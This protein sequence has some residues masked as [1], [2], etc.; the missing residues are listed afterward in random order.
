MDT[1][2]LPMGVSAE[3]VS[4]DV[5]NTHVT[6]EDD[7]WVHYA[8][9]LKYTVGTLG[10]I[11]FTDGILVDYSKD[12]ELYISHGDSLGGLIAW[13]G[14]GTTSFS[15]ETATE[16]LGTPSSSLVESSGTGNIFNSTYAGTFG[17]DT[18]DVADDTLNT[19][20]YA[21]DGDDT[22]TGNSA[23]NTI[24]GGAG[25]DTLDGGG[26]SDVLYGGA[27][28]DT[29][30]ASDGATLS[31]GTGDDTYVFSPGGGHS[32]IVDT[33]GNNTLKV[34]TDADPSTFTYTRV[35]DDLKIEIAS[36]VTISNYYTE[37]E[38]VQTIVT[39]DGTTTTSFDLS[40]FA[41]GAD[42][43]P[44]AADD[45]IHVL[46]DVEH[47]G[48]VL[49]SNHHGPDLDAD[50]DP[51]SVTALDMDTVHGHVVLNTDG[52]FAYTPDSSYTGTDSFDYTLLDGRGASDTA[53]VTLTVVANQAPIANDDSF[54]GVL[55]HEVIGNV[56]FNNGNGIDSD[57][58]NDAI[59]VTAQDADTTDGH[60]VLNTDGSFTYTPTEGFT[61]TDS[62][63]YTLTDSYGA[64]AT[65][66]ATLSI[67]LPDGYILGTSGIDVLTGGD[68]DNTIF[69]YEGDDTLDGEG[70]NNILQGG[71]GNDT[72][73][74]ST[75]SYDDIVDSDGSDRVV[76]SDLAST[77]FGYT[78]DGSILQMY[79]T[80]LIGTVDDLDATIEFAD[81]VYASVADLYEASGTFYQVTS[82][83]DFIDTQYS[84]WANQHR[85][86]GWKRSLFWHGLQ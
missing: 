24:Y 10:T 1:F 16:T 67:P 64:T 49:V 80:D 76:I 84:G 19:T 7:N 3:D 15:V 59:T 72:Y 44:V 55:D 68:E 63:D 11:T 50:G 27:G 58:D 25:N 85:S 60:V 57:P 33:E 69:G 74:I 53:T 70:G 78:F 41:A 5:V 56:R 23:A 26:G 42:T 54:A 13:T 6:S 45:S 8:S 51:L 35:G 62:F 17:N 82:G 2:I 81:G 12:S 22:I 31:G 71:T 65:A 30:I 21:Y 86:S 46:P 9:D 61:G 29:L 34:M 79:A 66:T 32:V 73:L 77:D 18:I 14:S 20:I 47:D 83:D 75:A 48:N 52:T 43:Q 28:N 39:D 37:P 4:I 40:S 38:T 36:G